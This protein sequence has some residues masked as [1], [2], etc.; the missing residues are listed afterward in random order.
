[1]T[2]EPILMISPLSWISQLPR[3]YL[4]W[5]YHFQTWIQCIFPFQVCMPSCLLSLAGSLSIQSS[6]QKTGVFIDFCCS[7][8]IYYMSPWIFNFLTE[9]FLLL[10]SSVW[11]L[12]M[13]KNVC[14]FELNDWNSYNSLLCSISSCYSNFQLVYKAFSSFKYFF[15]LFKMYF[16]QTVFL[17]YFSFLLL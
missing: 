12:T 4:E 11:H 10:I 15:H 9:N 3:R 5:D 17:Y 13:L 16:F 7:L 2:P 8:S 1:M 6:D 14:Q